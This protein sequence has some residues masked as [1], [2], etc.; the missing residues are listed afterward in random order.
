MPPHSLTIDGFSVRVP[1]NAPASGWADD[2]LRSLFYIG[3]TSYNQAHTAKEENRIED[4]L[5]HAAHAVHII[6]Y[7]EQFLEFAILLA[8]R[9][10]AFEEA[11]CWLSWAER[12]RLN[13]SWPGYRSVLQEAVDRW[14]GF[15]DRPEALFDHYTSST[16][17]VSYRELLFL[18]HCADRPDCP[19]L[20]NQALKLLDAYSIPIPPKQ[21]RVPEDAAEQDL[22][23]PPDRPPTRGV[24]ASTPDTDAKRT[25]PPT[26]ITRSSIS[27]IDFLVPPELSRAHVVWASAGGMF[28]LLMG[29]AVGVLLAPGSTLPPSEKIPESPPITPTG[30]GDI[31]IAQAA[32]LS[33][34]EPVDPAQGDG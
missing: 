3:A 10:G 23:P 34:D 7:C 2:L 15:Q 18:A 4:A 33:A 14:N 26:P 21:Q 31:H 30:P 13:E 25:G 5:K 29:V 16:T 11:H 19:D 6:P 9:H 12:N 27:G 32:R 17:D 1:E 24:D 28:C 20:P 22:S 8:I